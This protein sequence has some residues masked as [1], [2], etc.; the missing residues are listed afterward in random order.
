MEREDPETDVIGW[1]NGYWHNESVD[2][3][4]TGGLNQTDRDAVVAR[5]MARVEYLREAEFEHD[6]SVEVKTRSEHRESNPF[7]QQIGKQ[8]DWNNLVWEGLFIVD[9]STNVS[10]EFQEYYDAGVLGY[11]DPPTNSLVVLSE[12]SDSVRMSEAILIHELT[13][14]L[15]DQRFNLNQPKYSPPTQDAAL[16][17]KGLVEG[18]AMYIHNQYQ[19]R[20]GDEWDCLTEPNPRPSFDTNRGVQLTLAQ[21]YSDGG[22]YITHLV[23][24]GGWDAVD[25]AFESPPRET[26]AIIHPDTTVSS[27][28]FDPL[29][30]QQNGWEKYYYP[31]DFG[32]NDLGETSVFVM[33]WYQNYEYDID[34][35]PEES[36]QDSSGDSHYNHSVSAGLV[37]DRFTP[38]KNGEDRGYVW[39]LRWETE[40]DAREFTQMYE[41]IL[42]G[43]GSDQRNDSTWV[44]QSGGYADAFHVDQDGKTVIITNAPRDDQLDELRP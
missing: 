19:D 32:S 38:Y 25:A 7:D 30:R 41:Q 3:N 10:T 16:A 42:A 24:N 13:H 40:E 26:A 29:S 35:I 33:L 27:Y 17:A 44:I 21:P 34:T 31:G 20:C 8:S 28:Q 23:Q 36:I 43:H 9:E 14:A 37:N 15:Q 11:Y 18:E 2:V 5:S 4:R 22:G 1:E 12:N 6:V 39:R